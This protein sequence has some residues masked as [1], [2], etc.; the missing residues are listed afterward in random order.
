[1][2]DYSQKLAN[3]RARRQRSSVTALKK[4]ESYATDSVSFA[5]AYESATYTQILARFESCS[6]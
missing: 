1:M 2:T 6:G 4:S 5:E 3:M